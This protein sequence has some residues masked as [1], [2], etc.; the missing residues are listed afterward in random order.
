MQ[1]DAEHLKL[2]SIFQYV[3]AGMIAV[4]GCFPIIHVALGVMMVSGKGFAP[5]PPGTTVTFSGPGPQ[6]MGWFFIAVGG[7]IILMA[8]TFAVLAFLAGRWL[9]ARKKPTFCMVV[10]GIECL[11]VPFGT[12]LG[13]FTILVLQ[14][15]T[16][17][18]LFE[19]NQRPKNS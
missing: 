16:V 13:V 10:A 4:A 17:R 14:R 5:P 15:P 3:M 8:Q 9:S 12:V 11:A 7:A 18:A 1:A 19:E 2:L 6:E